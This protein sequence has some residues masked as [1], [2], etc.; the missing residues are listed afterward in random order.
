MSHCIVIIARDVIG[1][2]LVA[3]NIQLFKQS[4]CTTAANRAHCSVSIEQAGTSSL[5]KSSLTNVY[6][7]L[8]ASD[9]LFGSS[10]Y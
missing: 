5:S 8:R 9:S 6:K 7:V 2:A 10:A 4:R 3:L 1:S